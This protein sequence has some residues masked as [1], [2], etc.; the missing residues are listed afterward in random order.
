M[1]SV[2][3]IYIYM[4]ILFYRQMLITKETET[5]VNV[6]FSLFFFFF[7][8]YF[9]SIHKEY[10]YNRFQTTRRQDSKK[11]NCMSIGKKK[12]MA[13]YKR[14]CS[15]PLMS[16]Y[17]HTCQHFWWISL[18]TTWQHQHMRLLMKRRRKN[19]FFVC[20]CN[21]QSISYDDKLKIITID[22]CLPP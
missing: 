11:Q 3:S 2:S 22:T 7:S 19:D 10:I 17:S 18:T 4:Y 14:M 21:I 8:Y 20:A 16:S 9:E 6:Y 15:M 1:T 13:M 5:A 12:P